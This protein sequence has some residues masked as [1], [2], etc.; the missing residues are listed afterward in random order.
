MNRVVLAFAPTAI[1]VAA[2]LYVF[3]P[4]CSGGDDAE[5]AQPR[6]SNRTHVRDTRPPT[7]TD[8]QFAVFPPKTPVEIA[9]DCDDVHLATITPREHLDQLRDWMLLA[10]LNDA[11]L[12]VEEL[13]EVVHDLPAWR[14]GF[15]RAAIRFE[16]GPARSRMI[17]DDVVIALIPGGLPVKERE[18][19]LAAVLDEQRKNHDVKPA[20]LTLF[21]YEIADDRRR[22]SIVRQPSV[23]ALDFFEN[24]QHGYFETTIAS[25]DDLRGFIGRTDDVTYVEA[26]AGRL[27]LGGRAIDGF[28]GAELE[29]VAALWQAENQ[30][31]KKLAVF[32]AESDAAFTQLEQKAENELK[33][34]ERRYQAG[35]DRLNRQLG[36]RSR[37]ELQAEADVL[38]RL[39]TAQAERV[40]ARLGTDAEQL[41]AEWAKTWQEEGIVEATGF[42][43]DPSF[44]YEGL[45][46]FVD[47]LAADLMRLEEGTLVAESEAEWSAILDNVEQG[48]MDPFWDSLENLGGQRSSVI[49]ALLARVFSAVEKASR[50]L[51]LPDD[52]TLATYLDVLADEID[53]LRDETDA[54]ELVRAAMQG[55]T[56]DAGTLARLHDE[57]DGVHGKPGDA[58]ATRI[59]GTAVRAEGMG[60]ERRVRA[61]EMLAG[62][63]RE[64]A[65]LEQLATAL[66]NVATRVRADGSAAAYEEWAAAVPTDRLLA[67][68]VRELLADDRQALDREGETDLRGFAW[69]IRSLATDIRRLLVDSSFSGVRRALV[70]AADAAAGGDA[71]PFDDLLGQLEAADSEIA[72]RLH[73]DLVQAMMPFREIDVD[74][75]RRGL[76]EL[77]AA[78]EREDGDDPL[79]PT[80]LRLLATALREGDA[81][82]GEEW[83]NGLSRVAQFAAL[84]GNAADAS[85]LML[86]LIDLDRAGD[87]DGCVF[88]SDLQDAVSTFKE[89]ASSDG[90]PLAVSELEDVAG[91]LGDRN[92]LPFLQMIDRLG[93]LP[94]DESAFLAQ[95]I[96]DTSERDYQFQAARYDGALLQGTTVGM[97]LFYTDLLAKLWAID[98]EGSTPTKTIDDFIPMTAQRLSPVFAQEALE[99]PNTR[100]WFGHQSRGMRVGKEGST[101]RLS[102][103]RYTTRVY[104]ASSNPLAP[105][106]ETEAAAGSAAFLGW[107]NDHYEE[108]ALYEPQYQRLNAI[109][110][111]GVL[112]AWI[113]DLG[114]FDRLIFLST[115]DVERD[116][117]FA[118]WAH[119]NGTTLAF[120]DW[121]SVGFHGPGYRGSTTETLPLL[122]SSPYT[123]FDSWG[124]L[125]GGVS[126]P[127]RSG[128]ARIKP[129]AP[130]ALPRH[131]ARPGLVAE[132][133]TKSGGRVNFT[134]LD[135]TRVQLANGATTTTLRPGAHSRTATAELAP[136]AFQTSCRRVGGT[137]VRTDTVQ[138]KNLAAIARSETRVEVVDG[139]VRVK[140]WPRETITMRRL[141]HRASET[142]GDTAIMLLADADVTTVIRL[143]EFESFLVELRNGRWI[144]LRGGNSP[145]ARIGEQVFMRGGSNEAIFNYEVSVLYEADAWL[146]VQKHGVIRVPL[147]ESVQGRRPIDLVARGPP[148]DGT[149]ATSATLAGDVTIPARV[150]EESLYIATSEFEAMG[151]A[152]QRL[153][154]ISGLGGG[155]AG[156]GGPPVRTTEGLF[157]FP[158][159]PGGRGGH[160]INAW[161]R[162]RATAEQADRIRQDPTQRAAAEK[163]GFER[164]DRYLRGDQPLAAE[165]LM[166]EMQAL[167]S[168]SE[169]FQ[170]PTAAAHVQRGDFSKLQTLLNL[171]APTPTIEKAIGALERRLATEAG[172]QAYEQFGSLLR[173]ARYRRM[174]SGRAPP[175][176]SYDGGKIRTIHRSEEVAHTRLANVEDVISAKADLYLAGESSYT[177]GMQTTFEHTLREAVDSGAMRILRVR[178]AEVARARPDRLE[179]NWLLLT[180][181]PVATPQLWD[182]VGRTDSNVIAS[183]YVYF[184]VEASFDEQGELD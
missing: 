104:A 94:Y 28:L 67:T 139:V 88:R 58:L 93:S 138:R 140:F 50:G 166:E 90:G 143:P 116:H 114:Y 15:E 91:A 37:T 118:D 62:V 54:L 51:S 100:L 106:Q 164:V 53:H 115:V 125:S 9:F 59:L 18:R 73:G 87:R 111:W 25:L 110:K 19:L 150:G 135:G 134:T 40:V 169:H 153:Q 13:N 68:G 23:S 22:A 142:P 92:E 52:A 183:E 60:V 182:R 126:L 132:S 158:K 3:L 159:G 80:T 86:V 107:W 177:T 170:W 168:Q 122:R 74:A 75:A 5:Q 113:G 10:V 70:T 64:W 45:A 55:D 14:D 24:D 8:E 154:K 69:S 81:A 162:G 131:A 176:W 30:V 124:V 78:V 16:H 26:R 72:V 145:T 31:Q 117:R 144:T 1:L 175:R 101:N 36:S 108:V 29:H 179:L 42:S 147:K 33:A 84:L 2:S 152:A 83:R 46:T 49:G 66:N 41:R 119:A 35:I 133:V 38:E 61:Q 173:Y 4:G 163:I 149:T 34:I 65:E 47:R 180:G 136:T 99:L 63:E 123:Q 98:F 7:P 95:Q 79:A 96:R 171:D 129:I 137:L 12:T 27:V 56:L 161:Q 141:V 165:R 97:V 121:T 167:G 11:G 146:L 160:D 103:G 151:S 148:P 109:M 57:I 174:A 130:G 43:L 20:R 157:E 39:T 120:H 128:I 172:K 112:L 48:E 89:L 178:A 6:E 155:G 127:S 32:E 71:K 102:M 105:G 21:E 17:K 85:L 82:A 156:G 44:D 184:L 77:V 181:D 76:E